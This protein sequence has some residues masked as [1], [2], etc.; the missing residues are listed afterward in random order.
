MRTRANEARKGQGPE[1]EN[2]GKR[3]QGGARTREQR[4][5]DGAS[6]ISVN[7]SQKYVYNRRQETAEPPVV[8]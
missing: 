8:E 4:D 6:P 2:R 7:L 5:Q 1:S 3:G